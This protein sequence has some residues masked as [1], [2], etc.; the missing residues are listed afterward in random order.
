MVIV[1]RRH[2]EHAAFK[3]KDAAQR[4][5]GMGRYCRQSSLAQ[6]RRGSCF[7]PDADNTRGYVIFNVRHNRY[8]LITHIHYAK[9]DPARGFHTRPLLHPV[10]SHTRRVQQSHQLGQGVR[11]MTPLA[12]P[13]KMIQMG[14]PRVIHT[15][16]ELDQYARALFQLTAKSRPSKAELHA[17]E[18]L[19]ML[20][21][22]YE[23]RV[24]P[25]PLRHAHRGPALPHGE[26]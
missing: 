14:A 24:H 7:F 3:D 5:E 8:R 19:T 1:T 13:A 23:D 6:L 12:N 20:I 26:A 17:I 11:I 2:L 18:L 16:E 4:V 21:E 22:Q 15:E 25:N 9:D 10:V